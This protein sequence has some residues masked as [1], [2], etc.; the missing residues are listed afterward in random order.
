MITPLV[1]MMAVG[2]TEVAAIIV[3]ML[4]VTVMV[5]SDGGG[6]DNGDIGNSVHDGNDRGRFGS[7]GND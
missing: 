2:V 6:D 4:M 5:T 1:W 3:E 7:Y